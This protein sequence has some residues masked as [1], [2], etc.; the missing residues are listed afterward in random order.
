[1]SHRDYGYPPIQSLPLVVVT[2]DETAPRGA[3]WLKDEDL[4]PWISCPSCKAVAKLGNHVVSEDGMVM[5][6]VHCYAC[7][8]NHR[9]HLENF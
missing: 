1:M 6:M 3:W 7:E 5:G 9:L 2:E 8:R 4:T